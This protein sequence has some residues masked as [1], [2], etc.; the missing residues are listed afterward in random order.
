MNAQS[1]TVRKLR[2]MFKSRSKI[3][4]KV[5][6]W[7]FVLPLERTCQKEHTC[8]FAKY[9]S[10]IYEDQKVMANDKVY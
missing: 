5:T 10:L 7:K 2:L 3:M 8:V 4:V 6:H 1:L 9:E